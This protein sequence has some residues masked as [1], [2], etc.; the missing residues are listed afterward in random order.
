MVAGYKA[1]NKNQ[2]DYY[3]LAMNKLEITSIPLK[4]ACKRIRYL[5]I[6]LTKK[7]NVSQLSITKHH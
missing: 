6:S 2:L 5:G 7:C 1:N 3:T 4:I